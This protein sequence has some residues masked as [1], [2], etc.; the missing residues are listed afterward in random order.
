METSRADG[1]SQKLDNSAGKY[2]LKL[3]LRLR[4]LSASVFWRKRPVAVVR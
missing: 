4:E 1:A 3:F 2:A